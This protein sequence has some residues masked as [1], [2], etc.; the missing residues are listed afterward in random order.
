[1]V[2]KS[3]D[4]MG[5]VCPYPVTVTLKALGEMKKGDVLKILTNDPLAIKA[6]PEEIKGSGFE[7]DVERLARGWSINIIKL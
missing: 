3:I 2:E 7:T 5:K 6:I 1:M 4:V